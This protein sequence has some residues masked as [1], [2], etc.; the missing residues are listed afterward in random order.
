VRTR[1]SDGAG[2]GG[3]TRNSPLRTARVSACTCSDTAC[4]CP[5]AARCPPARPRVPQP[6]STSVILRQIKV[7]AALRRTALRRLE[8]RFAGAS[9]NG[10]PRFDRVARL[11]GVKRR[12]G[13]SARSRP[14]GHRSTA[15]QTAWSTKT[16]DGTRYIPLAAVGKTRARLA[17]ART[18]DSRFNA[19]RVSSHRKIA[20]APWASP[21]PRR[22][23]R[24][25]WAAAIETHA[26]R[27]ARDAVTSEPDPR[28]R[29]WRDRAFEGA[30]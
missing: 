29:S 6:C 28:P 13:A 4:W 7:S 21:A 10:R 14:G 9:T 11:D 30:S 12:A 17:T 19:P 25:L 8:R 26:P 24:A 20:L 1:G 22:P 23:R 3:A 16:A 15:L 2:F 18:V 5:G 27:A